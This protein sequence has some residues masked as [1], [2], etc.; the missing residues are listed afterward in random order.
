MRDG[1]AAY[2]A[3]GL[4]LVLLTAWAASTEDESK[5]DSLFSSST[6]VRPVTGTALH[7]AFSTSPLDDRFVIQ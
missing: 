2:V 4:G 1:I 3:G 6:S 7:S 5:L